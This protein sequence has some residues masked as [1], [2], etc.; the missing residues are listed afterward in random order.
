MD[1][2]EDESQLEH[3]IEETEVYFEDGLLHKDYELIFFDHELE[4]MVVRGRLDPLFTELAEN[5]KLKAVLNNESL[6]YGAGQEGDH[7]ERTTF[8]HYQDFYSLEYGGSFNYKMRN[9]DSFYD[10]LSDFLTIRGQSVL[11]SVTG[12]PVNR[13]F[14]Y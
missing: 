1:D 13:S 8:K 3:V 2:E 14:L 7:L 5:P 4:D 10:D 12:I 6:I 9:F 11:S